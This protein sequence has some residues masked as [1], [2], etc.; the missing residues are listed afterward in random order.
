VRRRGN[1]SSGVAQQPG[2][3]HQKSG[4]RWYRSP[5][6]RLMT[7]TKGRRHPISVRKCEYSA[8]R[9]VF[10]RRRPHEYMRKKGIGVFLESANTVLRVYLFF[11]VPRKQ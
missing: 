2:R 11:C 3:R 4:R 1:V 8:R 6:D 9:L 10:T 7:R 5:S